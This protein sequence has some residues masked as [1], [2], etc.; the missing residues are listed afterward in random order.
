MTNFWGAKNEYKI[1][2]PSES[3]TPVFETVFNIL[4]EDGYIDKNTTYNYTALD[5]NQ[6]SPMF[7]YDKIISPGAEVD[8]KFNWK[9]RN[10]NGGRPEQLKNALYLLSPNRIISRL[11]IYFWNYLITNKNYYQ[12]R[13]IIIMMK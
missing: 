12:L 10:P 4:S 5:K 2:V 1:E 13:D 3:R 11:A 8:K 7:Y 6:T 9:K